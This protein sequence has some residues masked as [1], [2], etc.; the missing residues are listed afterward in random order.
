[1]REPLIASPNQGEA[2]RSENCGFSA[3]CK[4]ASL[5]VRLSFMNCFLGP[6]LSITR[7]I[8]RNMDETLCVVGG[9]VEFVV[10]GRKYRQAAGSVVFVPKGVHDGFTNHGP[11]QARVLVLFTPAG[12]QHEYF[13]RLEQLFAAPSLDTA[14]LQGLQKRYDQELVPL[15][16]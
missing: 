2:S 16:S 15:D 11:G 6:L 14:A 7:S 12:S 3:V 13:R 1:V 9:E 4:L 10:T 5:Q 8:H